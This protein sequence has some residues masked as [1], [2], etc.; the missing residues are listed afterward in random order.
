MNITTLDKDFSIT[1]QLRHED[2]H[3]LAGKGYKTIINNRPDFEQPGQPLS[4]DLHAESLKA[5]L[6]YHHIP[7]VPGR[8]TQ[9]D[10]E[11]FRKALSESDGPVLAFCK[12]GMR[13]KAMYTACLR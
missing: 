1:Q 13:A 7:I 10:L 2:V 11:N 5:G 4:D 3:T 12:S 9:L 6:K 8:A